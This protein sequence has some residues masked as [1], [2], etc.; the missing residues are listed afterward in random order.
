M[1]YGFSPQ[2]KYVFFVYCVAYK[3]QIVQVA[4]RR[5]RKY[6]SCL[7]IRGSPL[8]LITYEDI[9]LYGGHC[10]FSCAILYSS[11]FLPPVILTV[12]ATA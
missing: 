9:N 5:I 7:K 12:A 1:A 4:V 8:L 2:E 3:R 6:G 11:F 10:C